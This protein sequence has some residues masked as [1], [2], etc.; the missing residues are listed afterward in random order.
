MLGRELRGA[1]TAPPCPL[2]VSAHHTRMPSTPSVDWPA[3]PRAPQA[4]ERASVSSQ[5]AA[6]SPGG[7]F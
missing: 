2:L 5:P 4:V 1:C 7:G 6:G 3:R